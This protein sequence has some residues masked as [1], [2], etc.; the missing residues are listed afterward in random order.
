[1]QIGRSALLSYQSALQ[2]IGNNISNAGSPDYTRQTPGLSPINGPG[3]PEGMRPGS[4]VAL[5]SLKRNLDEA[6]EN[7]IR[8]AAGQSEAALTSRQSL[9]QVEGLFDPVTGLQLD[10][11]IRDLF[12]SI[13]D[14][15]NAPADNAT[16]ELAISS[17]IGLANSLRQMRSRLTELGTQF[18]D[19]IGVIV[20]QANDLASRT[21]EL[22]TEIVTAEATGSP[23]SA[24]RDQRDS[25][26]RELS[27][28]VNIRVRVQSDGAVNVYIGNE[29]IVQ[30]GIS[31]GLKTTSRLDGTFQR[32]DVVFADN[33]NQVAI[34]GGQLQGLIDAREKN[35]FG[36]IS[37]IDQLASGIVFEVNKLHADGQGT[38]GFTSVTSTYTV[39]D[40]TAALG[41]A[42]AGLPFTPVNGGFY[43]AVTDDSSG[44]TVG[45]QIAVDL[46]GIGD[47]DTT[48]ESLAASINATATGVSAEI[49][50][51]NRLKLTADTGST[52]SFGFD[53]QDAR[54]DTSSTLASL[55]INTFFEG[56]SAVDV[57]VND[58]LIND[59][60]LFAAASVNLTGDGTNASRLAVLGEKSS[61]LL[62]G[63]SISGFYT[64]VA[65]S[66][67]IDSAGARND[68]ET[69][70]TVL[71]SLQAQ[72]ENISGV[73]L[74]EEAIEL[75]KFERAFQGAARFIS[76]VDRL[77]SE[78]IALVS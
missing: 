49:T 19:D 26:L 4:G 65:G 6:L 32:D 28:I 10:E 29:T 13:N 51:D 16:R 2:I 35:A 25:L 56:S 21:A 45:Y 41:S 33:N 1:M 57:A 42:E 59:A 39:D 7:R 15:Q 8:A 70:A 48:L 66:V 18:N 38:T 54:E 40:P 68:A 3:L 47:D 78:L 75:V 17:G 67:A 44:A 64:S 77:S 12:N 60:R 46:D 34:R 24:L 53:G 73:S 23:A 30:A 14:V 22:N 27:D 9:G 5:T 74:D 76:V 58:V 71:G 61:D 43:I 63:T 55:G 52:F 31:R 11:R 69:T 62:N 20:E 37:Q 36:R 50:I 72:K